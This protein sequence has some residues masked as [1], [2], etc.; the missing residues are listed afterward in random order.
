MWFFF[1]VFEWFY[2]KFLYKSCTNPVTLLCSKIQR[3]LKVQCGMCLCEH[4]QAEGQSQGYR[5]RSA[6]LARICMRRA[7][8]S[9][10]FLNTASL[11][12]RIRWY[13]GCFFFVLLLLRCLAPSAL[14]SL[15]GGPGRTRPQQCV[16]SSNGGIVH[17]LFRW[18]ELKEEGRLVKSTCAPSPA[19][20]SRAST[21]IAA[22]RARRLSTMT[23]GIN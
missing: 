10:F 13:H 5:R 20:M 12:N 18:R 9:V 2:V 14:F 17:L 16:V 22:E 15:I 19:Q 11:E 6:K 7:L 21:A 8:P 1:Y 4:V 23:F 3:T